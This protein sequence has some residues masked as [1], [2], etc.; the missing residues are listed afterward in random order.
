MKARHTSKWCLLLIAGLWMAGHPAASA[1]ITRQKALQNAREFLLQ[2]GISVNKVAMRHSPLRHESHEQDNA[3][4]YVI[5]I[6]DDA[7][8]V[9]ASGDD[10]TP[11]VL[12]YS[13]SGAMDTDSLPENVRG[14]LNSYGEQIGRLDGQAGTARSAVRRAP[15]SRPPV[16]PMLTSKWD[17]HEPY[18]NNCPMVANTYVRCITGCVATAMAQVMYYH[19]K[20]STKKILADIPTYTCNDGKMQVKGTEKGT[21]IDW[22]NMLDS[23]DR[24]N[25]TDA[26]R[27]AVANLLF[28]CGSSIRMNYTQY[29]SSPSY[30][31]HKALVDYFDYDTDVR[32]EYRSN[33]SDT[34]WETM[35]YDD[36]GKGYPLIYSGCDP[37]GHC[38]VVDGHDGNGYVHINWGWG[39]SY[40]GYFLLSVST[41]PDE[42]TMGGYSDAQ[43]AIFG[44]VPNGAFPKL[45]TLELS[46]TGSTVVD[47][48]SSRPSIPV[49]LSMTAANLTDG[50]HSFEQAIGLYKQGKLQSIVSQMNVIDDMASGSSKKQDVAF[51]LE[52][53]LSQGAYILVP[54]SRASGSGKWRKNDND[55]FVTM[56]VSGDEAKLVV[57][58]PPVQGDVIKFACEETKRVCVENWDANGDGELS[59][60]EAAAVT[61]LNETF[62]NNQNITSF[63][64]LEYF[65][66]LTSI[67]TYEFFSCY[68]LTSVIIP[69][70]V[71]S[72]GWDAFWGSKLKQVLIPKGI[73]RIEAQAFDLD[74]LE[75]I[76]VEEGNA[77]Y[78]SR[79]DCNAIIETASNTLVVGCKNT[80]IPQG[81]TAIGDKAFYMCRGLSSLI[82]PESLTSIGG[83][84]F[85]TC[86]ALSS[87]D[88]PGGVTVI[89]SSAFKSCRSLQSVNLPEGLIEIGEEAFSSTGIGSVAIPASLKIIRGNPFA[90]CN[91]TSMTVDEDNP[92]FD[93]RDGCNAIMESK[94]DK[95]L[96]AC[97]TTVIPNGT[98]A[99]GDNAFT[100][101]GMRSID[102]PSSVKTI[103]YRSFNDCRRLEHLVIPE[104][105]EKIGQWAFYDCT[106]L[107]TVTLPSTMTQIDNYAF[108]FCPLRSIVVKTETPLSIR[109]ETFTSYEK[110]M[111]Y[112]PVGCGA[113][114]RV[115]SYWK[116]F[117]DIV[118][119]DLPERDIIHFADLL[120]KDICVKNWDADDDGELSREEAATVKD[121]GTNFRRKR[122]IVSF[123]ELQHFTGLTSIADDAFYYC[124]AMESITLP[125]TITSIGDHTF[126]CCKKM[127]RFDLP[128][129]LESIKTHAFYDCDNLV[130]INI[131]EN[132]TSIGS[133][134]FN[135]CEK[136]RHIDLPGKVRELGWGAFKSCVA[137][138]TVT[139]HEGL[140]RIGNEAFY[141]CA[142]LK[143]IV[144]P[145]S[146]DS[147]GNGIVGRCSQLA[148][149][150]VNAGNNK[151]DSRDN[152]NGIVKTADNELMQACKN[153]VIP[154]TVT[155]IS[156]YAFRDCTPLESVFIPASVSAVKNTCND[157][158][159]W[160][161]DNLVSIKVDPAN[162]VYDS[163]GNCNAIIKTKNN[164]LAYGCQGTILP[165]GVRTIG[166]RAFY[167]CTG[168]KS[169]VVPEG[170][171]FIDDNAFFGC[172]NMTSI[173]LPESLTRLGY[174]VFSEC[175]GLSSIQLPSRLKTIAYGSYSKCNGL[176][177]ITVPETVEVID[178]FSFEYCSN[179]R[180]VSIPSKV[181]KIGISAFNKCTNL[182]CVVIKIPAPPAITN[183]TFFNYG[184]ALLYVPKGCREAYLSAENWRNFGLIR[185]LTGLRGD[186]N[187][188]G[189]VS[190][191][192]VLVVV[193]A[194]LGKGNQAVPLEF[195]DM[196]GDGSVTISDVLGVVDVI[197]NK[198]QAE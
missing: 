153:T 116:D 5:N 154:N 27:Q 22:D 96:V 140:E 66:G 109:H 79:N 191:S 53:T 180:S 127:T 173:S 80:T 56:V 133:H 181:A 60:D 14:W 40:D 159:F 19:R 183:N 83:L 25:I 112:V 98:V 158:P 144:I 185:E 103:G 195:V 168:L 139:M 52:S 188:D 194:I 55:L 107:T 84:A 129:T 90:S 142:S 131:P 138:E 125:T 175:H 100:G 81:I 179:L 10:R 41:D 18:N 92:Y 101:C 164:E 45:T 166:N 146:V 78:D 111:L 124:D 24:G 119:G 21:P 136:L 12:A 63:D 141:N 106:R 47:G 174:N 121:L 148:L 156:G 20:N 169:I 30:S 117:K 51:E 75:S 68:K 61:S 88:I 120:V 23:Y 48:I 72:I 137:L 108:Y 118:E 58:T 171:T 94:S 36:L 44:A 37:V 34:E 186:V 182:E 8:F 190:I 130:E 134:A 1:P 198:T 105:V 59:K 70:N 28:Y 6:G 145:A 85:Y 9:I 13:D 157:S 150:K 147:I 43:D 67:G 167:E 50:T 95:L 54:L 74:E 42:G 3:P 178:K 57:S 155:S 115:A 93:S 187:Q 64:E 192:D 77:V 46:L 135:G 26:Q 110:A 177:N 35:V 33:Y 82:L 49:S 11:A 32:R 99:I 151:Y 65:T 184:N 123:D 161:C 39:G 126:C 104:G 102:I 16:S 165:D 89:N 29:S 91:V 176:V 69:K 62:K 113:I 17:Q 4:Y 196:N 86:N 38:F 87:I 2:K 114:Y 71:E 7:G 163:R 76:Q 143:A 152:C 132:V 193:D 162:A 170:V 189:T 97:N 31:P 128:S 73:R 149:I 15:V 122:D 172:E 197:L 160:G